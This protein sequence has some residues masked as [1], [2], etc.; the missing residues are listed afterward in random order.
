MGS[1]GVEEMEVGL[2][3]HFRVVVSRKWFRLDLGYSNIGYLRMVQAMQ[4]LDN[5]PQTQ[6]AASSA[7]QEFA[8]DGTY[9]RDELLNSFPV[10]EV[11]D[12]G[13]VGTE[14]LPELSPSGPISKPGFFAND[15]R[16]MDWV[17]RYS[18]EQPVI[19]PGDPEIKLNHSQLRAI[20]QM[21]GERISLIQG[22]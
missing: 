16:I 6:E 18:K 21:L 13:D 22:V 4:S 3:I 14:T 8:L 19:K 11:N 5:D 15:E 1:D 2:L 12:E 17:H 9:L 10:K 20:A 7:N